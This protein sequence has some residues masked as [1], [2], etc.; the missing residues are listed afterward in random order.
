MISFKEY[1]WERI[2]KPM[3]SSWLLLVLL[4]VCAYSVIVLF[5]K[6][7]QLDSS[8]RVA[9]F[10]VNQ[11]I[12]VGDWSLALGHLQALEKA[13][14][15]FDIT[16]RSVNGSQNVS[17]PF[18]EHPFGVGTFC[19]E[20][21]TEH[22]W[23]L[24]G[25]MRV[26]G[27]TEIYTLGLFIVFAV[28]VFG[29]AFRLFRSKSLFF[30][31]KISDELEEMQRESS[32]E[33]TDQ[34]IAEI[35]AIRQHITGLRQQTEEAS[36][37]KAFTELSIQVAHDIRS[38]LAALDMVVKDSSVLPESDRVLV[39]TA[40]SRITDIANNLINQYSL[41]PGL[42]DSPAQLRTAADAHLLSPLIESVTS[43]KRMQ[44]RSRM[45]IEI[46]AKADPDSYGLFA[47]IDTSEFKRALSNLIN[48]SVEAISGTG[49]II[50]TLSN[51]GDKIEIT[52]TDT[53]KGISP[54]VLPQLMRKGASFGKEGGTGL[55]LYYAKEAIESWGG[56]LHL[57]SQAGSGTTVRLILPK[58]ESP[59]WFVRE[60]T[61]EPGQTIAV[62]DD[63]PSIHQV[64]DGRFQNIASQ[65]GVSLVH[66]SA[67][68]HFT[69]WLR[70]RPKSDQ[71]LFLIDYEL[72]GSKTTGLDLIESLDIADKSTLVTS[73]YEDDFIRERAKRLQVRMIPKSMAAYVPITAEPNQAVLIDDDPIVHRIWD[74]AART[75]GRT[76]NSFS[77]VDD[78]LAKC[79]DFG[80]DTPIY[81]DSHLGNGV[82]GETLARAIHAQGFSKIYLVTGF[83]KKDFAP[84]PEIRG[85]MD[86]NPPWSA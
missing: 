46:L 11:S 21:S 39:R 77:N 31:G 80:S 27:W 24:R 84:T 29:I 23:V 83:S 78:F 60:L 15:V 22:L 3:W 86:K 33:E 4:S 75:A 19:S 25:C 59:D 74:R 63:D 58:A 51:V 79:A 53:G 67:P 17:G 35:R 43:E 9:I 56:A 1:L 44:Y 40:V 18:G 13:G 2:R 62:L 48:N 65:Y 81:L 12:Q 82:R 34:P 38:P 69:Q 54:D 49:Q 68:N 66:F 20:Q 70:E 57:E 85:I 41:V 36:R 71:A 73:R 10:T 45:G 8:L 6:A 55:G 37:N 64:W 76:L 72:L 26:F 42:A 28:L 16:L 30:I 32:N 5:L 7:R 14:P 50:V 47:N 52:I 61:I